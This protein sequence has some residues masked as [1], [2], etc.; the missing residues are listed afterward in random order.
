VREETENWGRGWAGKE[1]GHDKRYRRIC[2]A[3]SLPYFVKDGFTCRTALFQ[4]VRT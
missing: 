3:V 2:A 1:K 4:T